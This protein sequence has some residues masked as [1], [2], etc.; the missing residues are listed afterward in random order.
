M[1]D[2]SEEI[3]RIT[4]INPRKCMRCGKCSAVCPAYEEM[5][6]H[7]HQFVAMIERGAVEELMASRAIW[8]CLSCMA[9]LERC[10]RSVEPSRLVEAARLMVIRQAG[11]NHLLPDEIP[12]LLDEELPQQAL[13]SALRK[14]GK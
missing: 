14:Y 5:E 10:P 7:P 3:R 12:G 11:K 2:Y 13:V 9:C 6:Y 1:R 8:N 4:G